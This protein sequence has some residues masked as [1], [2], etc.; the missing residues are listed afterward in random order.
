ME[1]KSIFDADEYRL[2]RQR[3]EQLKPDSVRL[4]GK[5]NAAQMLAHACVPLEAGLGRIALPPEG[6]FITRPL[7]KWY[8]LR[9]REFQRNLPT[10]KNFVVPDERDFEREKARL[11]DDLDEAFRRGMAGPWALHN[12][13]GELAPEQWG[14]LTWAHL[15][16][17]LR[18]FSV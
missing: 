4:W 9:S 12:M 14:T 5:M 15:D 8:V 2:I 17:H 10:S 6:N 11:L 16:H 13:F 7:L 18:Q 3:I 1:R